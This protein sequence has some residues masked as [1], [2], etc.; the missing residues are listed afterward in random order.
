MITTNGG[1]KANRFEGDVVCCSGASQTNKEFKRFEI[2]L[3]IN[4]VTK[5]SISNVS[6]IY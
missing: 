4:K 2:K 6:E 1:V 5:D 3:I